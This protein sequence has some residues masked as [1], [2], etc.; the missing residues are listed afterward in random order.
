MSAYLGGHLL[1]VSRYLS[2]ESGPDVPGQEL[3]DAV[4]GMVGDVGEDV[5]QVVFRVDSVELGGAEQGVHGCSAFSSRVRAG[6]EE[7]D[8][9]ASGASD[10]IG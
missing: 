4:D 1:G 10:G 5:S 8:M 9:T 6:E 7:D 2:G 3:G